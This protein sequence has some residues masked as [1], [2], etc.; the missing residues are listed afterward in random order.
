MCRTASLRVVSSGSTPSRVSHRDFDRGAGDVLGD[1]DVNPVRFEQLQHR[2]TRSDSLP[3]EVRPGR[4]TRRVVGT[5]SI[6]MSA[7]GVAGAATGG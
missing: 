3:Q 7:G 2:A 5:G 1:C 4:S 6:H